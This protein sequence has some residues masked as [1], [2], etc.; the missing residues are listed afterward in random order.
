MTTTTK[1]PSRVTKE[2]NVSNSAEGKKVL[3]ASI[4][5]KQIK[6]KT[7]QFNNVKE[8]IRGEFAEPNE[9]TSYKYTATRVTK[10]GKTQVGV[11]TLTFK[12]E[13]TSLDAKKIM[14]HLQEVSPELAKAIENNEDLYSTRKSSIEIRTDLTEV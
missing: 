4:L 1:K 6:N 11:V 10:S 14:A 8:L 9:T 12:S 2:I 7:A 3:M 13:S 5:G